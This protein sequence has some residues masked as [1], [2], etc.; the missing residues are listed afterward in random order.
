M[1]R[2]IVAL[3]LVGTLAFMA[4]PAPAGPATKSKLKITKL[5]STGAAG[6]LSSRKAKCEKGR[7]VVLQFAG[8]YTTVRVGSDK[9]DGQGRWKINA[10]L[11]DPGVYYAK[12]KA[13]K[14]GTVKCAAA[15]SKGKTLS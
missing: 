10:S 2:I 11:T 5:S 15:E 7:K 13:V 14:R 12:T 3:T 9:T 1:K 6:T 8:E 4:A